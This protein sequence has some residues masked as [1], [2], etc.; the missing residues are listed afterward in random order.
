[1]DE[2]TLDQLESMHDALSKCRIIRYFES[3]EIMTKG[4]DKPR[5]EDKANLLRLHNE[6]IARNHAN[7]TESTKQH[8]LS[9][10]ITLSDIPEK[11]HGAFR[12]YIAARQ[13]ITIDGQQRYL[14]TDVVKFYKIFNTLKPHLV[15]MG[16]YEAD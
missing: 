6:V 13:S 7:M 16:R 8:H 11:D 1:M 3:G 12:A 10:T 4:E 15:R 2:I 9:S 14:K 5:T